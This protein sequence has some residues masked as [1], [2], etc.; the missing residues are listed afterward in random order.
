MHRNANSFDFDI[1]AVDW[2]DDTK[3]ILEK[4]MNEIEINYKDKFLAT[5]FKNASICKI[6]SDRIA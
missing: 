1:N 5:L 2:L 6:I 4:L 3:V